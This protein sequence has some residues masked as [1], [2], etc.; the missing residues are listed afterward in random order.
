MFAAVAATLGLSSCTETWDGNPV[1]ETHPEAETVSFLNVPVMQDQYLM[2]SSENKNGTL[3]MTCSQPDYGYAAIVTY[4]VQV[5]LD[6][7]YEEGK[8]IE[9]KTPSYDC[10]EINPRN[11]EVA[12]A[13]EKLLGID[14]EDKMPAEL[15][16]MKVYFRLRAYIAP[17]ETSKDN[18]TEAEAAAAGTSVYYSNVVAFNNI[19]ANY[20]A[21]WK[22][23]EKWDLYLRGEF[24]DWGTGDAWQFISGDEDNTWICKNVTIGAGVSIKISTSTWGDPNL[25]GHDGDGD[26]AEICTVDERVEMNNDKVSGHLRLDVDFH[27]DVI[28]QLDDDGKYYVIFQTT[29]D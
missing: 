26:A 3:H 27:G 18:M 28:L 7:Q 25:G 11:H 2:L 6:D 10:A 13:I 24:N 17:F 16:W 9:L 14:S 5:C 22:P 23:G 8:Y 20:Y 29:E 21:V 19:S 4:T 1:L 12:A 15:P